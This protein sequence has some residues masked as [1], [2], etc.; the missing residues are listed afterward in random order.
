M[1]VFYSA[2]VLAELDAAQAQLNRHT[3][4]SE[5]GRCLTCGEEDPCSARLV[6]LQVFGRYEELPR[7]WPG[8][9]RP[10]RV[11][12]FNSWPGWLTRGEVPEG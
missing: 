8:A 1:T 4:S 11:G 7:R 2:G 10:E 12:G 6:A 9:S 5:S 3:G